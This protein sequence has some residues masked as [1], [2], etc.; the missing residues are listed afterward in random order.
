MDPDETWPMGRPRPWPHCVTWGPSSP[1]PKKGARPP[2]FRPMSIVNLWPN[3]WM[4]QDAV[5]CGGRPWP[6]PHCARQGPSPPQKKKGAQPPVFGP[7]LSWPNSRPSQ[8][9]LSTCLITVR[10]LQTLEPQCKR[11]LYHHDL[12][13]VNSCACACVCVIALDVM[14]EWDETGPLQ[15]K[16]LR[17]AVRR[18][19]LKGGIPNTK[20]RGRLFL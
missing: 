8:L 14:K 3:G 18:I 7:C 12:Y 16:H 9:L 13:R 15:P 17:E 5:W 20:H 4:D 11:K 6:K 1:F 10:I 2:N 19:R